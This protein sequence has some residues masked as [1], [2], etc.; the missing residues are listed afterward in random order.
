VA[1]PGAVLLTTLAL[2]GPAAATGHAPTGAARA[3]PST[4]DGF[5]APTSATVAGRDLFVANQNGN[6]VTVVRKSNGAYVATLSGSGFGFD[7]PTASALLGGDVFVANG[8]GNSVTEVNPGSL[9]AM[10]TV[11]GSS[12]H[13]A[14]PMALATSGNDLYVLSADGTVTAISA[15]GALIGTA[16]GSELGITQPGGIAVSKG[17]VFVTDIAHDDVVVLDAQSLASTG[18]LTGS[19]YGFSAPTG[20]VA[21][22]GRL[23]VTN[24]TAN[25]VTE[26]S[27]ATGQP[28]RVIVDDA[29]LPTPGPITAGDNY[30][31]TL[32]PPGSSP[33]VT[34][35]QAKSGTVDWMMCNTNG[36]YDFNDP[37]GV[38]VAGSKLW[39]ANKGGNSLTEM[40]S[41]SGNLIRT[42]S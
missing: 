19:G 13:F 36:P 25:S 6:S 18:V 2:S 37:Q 40:D 10:R 20:V 21:H 38:A 7:Q 41:D 23:W 31:F 22:S 26:I 1:L 24:A 35:L 33:M 15:T 30:I 17:K 5:D 9:A 16:S 34:Q 28:V 29:N 39:V 4:G 11:S 14:D 8:G 12:Y 42:V 3:A 27:I 32:S